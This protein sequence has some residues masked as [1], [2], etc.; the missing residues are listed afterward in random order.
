MVV[1]R[2]ECGYREGELGKGQG[3]GA[4]YIITEGN[5]TLGGEHAIEYIA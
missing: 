4:G 1:T 3:L 5:Q 2:R